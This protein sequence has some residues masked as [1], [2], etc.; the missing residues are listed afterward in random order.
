[1]DGPVPFLQIVHISDLH[2]TDPGFPASIRVFVGRYI[3]KIWQ[4][5]HDWILDAMASHNPDA[6]DLFAD[7][8]EEITTRYPEPEW[9][10]QPLCIVDSGDLTTFGDQ[11]S[12]RMGW[13]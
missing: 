10:N 6:P 13:N 8:L 1:M 7:F 9:A 3:K 5:L 11:D 2:F 12:L 4:S